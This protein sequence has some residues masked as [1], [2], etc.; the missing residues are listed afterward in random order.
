MLF[1]IDEDSGSR[2]I[3][4]VMPDNPSTT[5]K[6]VVH[7]DAERHIVLDAFV[8]R[9]LLREQNLH[10]TGICG[11]V[12]DEN[13]CPGLTG[14]EH[15]EIKD[16]SNQLLIYRRRLGAQI[17]QQKFLRIETQLPRLDRLD[18][19]LDPRFH[20]AYHALELL[21]EESIRSIFAISFS[22][23]IY[24][25]GRI[26]WR[27]W[28]PLLRD[29]GFKAGILLR[30][31]FEELSER[32]LVLKWASLS[33]TGSVSSIL[34]QL[35]P[36]G[37]RAFK[38]VSLGDTNAVETLLSSPPDEL[39]ALVCDPF[40]RQL[41]APNH[42]DP[43]PQPETAAA[44]ESLAEIDVVGLREDT[45]SFLELLAFTLDL[46]HPF[47]SV[48]PPVSPTVARFAD[49]LREMRPARALIENDLELYSEVARI[50]ARP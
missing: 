27:L 7:L 28:E 31:P 23:S 46:A 20:M 1:S 43:P 14:A 29:R 6:V 4:W 24:A 34:G 47:P 26:Y 11:F 40:V 50:V 42:F 39:R 2:I 13:N 48:A 33:D 3:G 8:D 38:S 35:T 49:M 22:N 9:P 36:S 41:A 45:G 32:L 17:V 25:S 30:D 12:L 19:E 44:L 16:A 10:N 37:A 5:P 15:L 21:S 18:H